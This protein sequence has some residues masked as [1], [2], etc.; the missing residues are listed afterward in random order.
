[1]DLFNEENLLIAN[2][3]WLRNISYFPDCLSHDFL[4][5]DLNRIEE[6]CGER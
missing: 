1:M 5:Y 6:N 4:L 2:L 3:S